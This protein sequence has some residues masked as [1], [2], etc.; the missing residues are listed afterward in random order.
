MAAKKQ[1]QPTVDERLEKLV[2]RHEALTLTVELTALM[3]QTTE[4]ELTKLERLA[5][6]ILSKHNKRITALEKGRT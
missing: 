5:R 2:E 4:R 6:A 1:K 3:Q